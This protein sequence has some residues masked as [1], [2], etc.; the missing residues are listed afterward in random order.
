MPTKV[1]KDSV[2]GR[3]TTGHEWDG[4]KE[5]NTP[6]PKWWLYVFY[7][8]IIWSVV[9]WILYPSIPGITGYVHGVL[10]WSMREEHAE[11]M[12]EARASQAKFYDQIAAAEL[13]EIRGDQNLL[14]FALAGGEAAFA[15]NC[16]PCHGAGGSGRPGGYPVLAD[17]AWIWGG[18]L[19]DIHATIQYGVRNEHPDS[20]QSMMPA[21]ADILSADQL[22]DVASYVLSL[23]GE[24]EDPK[25]AQRGA[26]VFAE[27]CAACHGEDGKGMNALGAPNL[28]D[29]IWLYG[30]SKQEIVSQIA[31]PQHGVMPPWENRL[32]SETVKMLSVY[33]HSLG[34][35]Q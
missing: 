25:A 8:T 24:A 11:V 1:E 5:L 30:G 2:T 18:G 20:R 23:S 34:G 31:N 14:N 13:G 28:S 29:A 6:L 7:A 35:G 33:V 4:I 3:E 16:A 32:D 19:E 10:G 12:A 21:Y 15:D 17:D 22:T 9:Y 26:Q 27:Q